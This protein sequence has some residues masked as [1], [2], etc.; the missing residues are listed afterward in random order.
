MPDGEQREAWEAVSRG[1]AELLFLAPGQLAN[2]LVLEWVR[3]MRPGLVAVDEAH[4]VSAWGHDFRPDYLRLGE[5]V[6]AAGRTL[7]LDA[8]Q[9]RGLLERGPCTPAAS[10]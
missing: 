1:E 8:V 4:A 5:F 7:A 2:P 6:D 10:G 3:E 9:S